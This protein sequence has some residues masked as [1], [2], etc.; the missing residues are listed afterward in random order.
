MPTYCLWPSKRFYKVSDD[1]FNATKIVQIDEGT[2]KICLLQMKGVTGMMWV[3]TYDQFA[4][5]NL[6]SLDVTL[7]SLHLK[8]DF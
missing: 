8:K 5:K 4:F 2:S 7:L 3:A 6:R 1:A